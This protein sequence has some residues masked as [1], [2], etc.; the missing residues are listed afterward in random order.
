MAIFDMSDISRLIVQYDSSL[1][2]S[3]GWRKPV[4]DCVLCEIPFHNFNNKF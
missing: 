3:D 1:S 4:N 2:F